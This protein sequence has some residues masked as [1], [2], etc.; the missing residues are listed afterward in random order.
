VTENGTGHA[1]APESARANA[2]VPERTMSERS[3]RRRGWNAR[4]AAEVSA[5]VRRARAAARAPWGVIGDPSSRLGRLADRIEHELAAEYDTSRPVWV[6]AVRAAA[7]H[8][9]HAERARALVGI[10]ARATLRQ[11][12]AADAVAERLLA[13]VARN[14]GAKRL[15]RT[16]TIAELA[17][18]K[19]DHA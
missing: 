8:K 15:G 12:T 5:R 14:G 6:S 4:L 17:P 18:R 16:L 2:S 19:V 9:A 13:R 3:G 1:T 7:E 10:D 11:A